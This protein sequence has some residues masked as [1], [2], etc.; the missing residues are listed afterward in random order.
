MAPFFLGSTEHSTL[1]LR[2]WT[3]TKVATD[4]GFGVSQSCR[5]QFELLA[6]GDDQATAKAVATEDDQATA[7]AVGHGR[8]PATV[9]AVCQE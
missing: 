1:W 7:K 5:Q 6:T 2:V 4:F 8:L 9:R 3:Q